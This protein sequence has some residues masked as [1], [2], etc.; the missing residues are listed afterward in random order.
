MN[1]NG[2]RYPLSYTDERRLDNFCTSASRNPA[3]FLQKVAAAFVQS[4]LDGNEH[5]REKVGLLR[6]TMWIKEG[7]VSSLFDTSHPLVGN[8]F[9]Q[10]VLDALSYFE[11]TG[12]FMP[13]D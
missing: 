6:N 11:N 3:L 13:S 8:E 9:K 2:F 4:L 7:N 10:L 1:E 12:K 5:P